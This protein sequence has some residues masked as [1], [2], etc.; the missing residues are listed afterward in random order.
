MR[1]MKAMKGMRR[2]DDGDGPGND[3]AVRSDGGEVAGITQWLQRFDGVR[4][5][6]RAVRLHI[7]PEIQSLATSHVKDA[8]DIIVSAVVVE[9]VVAYH[10]HRERTH[11]L[12][13][14]VTNGLTG[15]V[16]S[17]TDKI[18]WIYNPS[19]V[20]AGVKALCSCPMYSVPL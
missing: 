7:D 1:G 4:E 19:N 15:F 9:D 10:I 13:F 17:N 6:S 20:R 5:R 16:L 12:V 8:A 2:T 18:C 3:G 11:F 14:V